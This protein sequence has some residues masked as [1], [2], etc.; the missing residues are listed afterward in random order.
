MILL[1][2]NS[3]LSVSFISFF[4]IEN[5]VG[6]IAIII[7]L[8]LSAIIAGSEIALFV[9]NPSQMQELKDN[10]TQKNKAILHLLTKPKHLLATMLITLNFINISIVIIS[11]YIIA[12]SFDI[13]HY[14][15]L[16]FFIQVVVV[17]FLILFFGEITPKVYATHHPLKVARY[18]IRP[19]SFIHKIVYPLSALLV[20]STAIID[21]RITKKGHNIS[22]N[23]LSQVLDM[24]TKGHGEE[25]TKI[26]KGIV[27][28]GNIDVKE[29]MQS[30]MDITAVAIGLKLPELLQIVYES[31]Y[32][33]LPVYEENFDTIKGIL[34]VKDLLPYFEKQEYEWQQLIRPPF[35]VPESKKINDLLKEFQHTKIHL[36]IVVDE[37]GGTSGIVTL[38]DIIEEIVG[39]IN[40]EF[41]AEDLVHSKLDENNYIFEAKVS[42]SDFCKITGIN[43]EVFAEVKG[44]SDTLAGLILELKGEIPEKNTDIV[45]KNFIF[46]IEA[47]DKRR[48]KRIKVT[49]TNET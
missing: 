2:I 35:F 32:S 41:D 47:A 25:E 13:I 7:L 43:P 20:N 14:P 30:R 15:V 24:T 49:L 3:I 40:D 31:G 11:S 33:R 28:F 12:H 45:Y 9:L 6:I 34:Y 44:D 37:Y 48:I 17:T 21:K 39:E 4:S 10:K 36:A 1:T 22:M 26:L 8:F 42:L 38:E 46:R 19:L 29:I 5:I 16:T 23:E 18:I 27:K